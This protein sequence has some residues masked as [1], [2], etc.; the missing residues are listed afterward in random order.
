MNSWLCLVVGKASSCLSGDMGSIPGTWAVIIAIVPN[1][2]NWPEKAWPSFFLEL[3]KIDSKILKKHLPMLK[4]FQNSNF[5]TQTAW[6]QITPSIKCLARQNI[7]KIKFLLNTLSIF[8][9]ENHLD[10]LYKFSS[11][12]LSCCL[13]NHLDFFWFFLCS[14][15][16]DHSFLGRSSK[17]TGGKF[18]SQ[19]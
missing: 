17:K 12:N 7:L 1:W 19:P 14:L 11:L 10:E 9:E 13:A 3:S 16:T 18:K 5:T 4:G 2:S 8:V 6:R 15:N